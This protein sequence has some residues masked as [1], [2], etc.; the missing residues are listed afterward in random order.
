MRIHPLLKA[1]KASPGEVFVSPTPG[2][3]ILIG[4]D[5]ADGGRDALE[6]GRL[7]GSIRESR[8]IA[9]IPE[10]GQ[11]ASEARSALGDPEIETRV[12]GALAPTLQLVESAKREDAGTLVVG[13]TRR[14]N[15]GRALLGSTAEQ[16]LHKAP[17]PVLVVPHKR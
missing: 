13:S 10:A 11:I 6:L 14:G 1:K 12:I 16:V 2:A 8:C 15:I 17:C 7:L 5:G 9:A 3:P 4:F